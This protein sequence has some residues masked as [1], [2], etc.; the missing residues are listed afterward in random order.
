MVTLVL[1]LY[2][3]KPSRE[4]RKH[5]QMNIHGVFLHVLGDALGSIVVII[6][7][8]VVWLSDWEHK[9]VRLALELSFLARWKLPR[10]H[11]FYTKRGEAKWLF[12]CLLWSLNFEVSCI[13]W[14][15]WGSIK[16]LTEPK[17]KPYWH[18]VPSRQKDWLL[19]C[20]RLLSVILSVCGP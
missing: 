13:F 6:S 9:E 15:N 18:C 4:R 16:N 14:G 3:V 5:S 7:A 2:Q 12:W 20:W 11:G 19:V 8:L 10:L 1:W 17:T